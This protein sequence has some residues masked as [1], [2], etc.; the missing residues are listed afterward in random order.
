MADASGILTTTFC[1]TLDTPL[2]TRE[3]TKFC[4]GPIKTCFFHFQILQCTLS[5]VVYLATNVFQ[6][7]SA[8]PMRHIK[9]IID[10]PGVYQ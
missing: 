6:T 2:V 10:C 9:A 5:Q 4:C 8:D 7:L 1:K 3:V